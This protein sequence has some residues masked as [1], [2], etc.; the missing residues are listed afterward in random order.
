MVDL[1]ILYD[2]SESDELGIRLTAE[3]KEIELEYIPFYKI[4]FGFNKNKFTFQSTGKD[5]SQVIKDC[6]VVLNR[7]QSKNRRIFAAS[8]MEGL[9]KEVV[10]PLNVETICQSKIRSLLKFM[11]K[12]INI[13]KTVYVPCNVKEEMASGEYIDNTNTIIRLVENQLVKNIVIKPDA[14]THG[15]SVS[16]AKNSEDLMK[17][18]NQL[19]T[20]ITN[21][22]GVVAQELIPKWFYDLRIIVSKEKNKKAFC[23]PT[24]LV[25]GGFKEFRTNTFLGNMVFHV[26]L[27]ENVKKQAE[28]C[29]KA[30]AND[31][32]AWLIALD[33]MPN[34]DSKTY[35][36]ENELK[37]KFTE[38]QEPFE[39]V[40]KVKA[41]P[42]KKS[43]FVKYS[44]NVEKAYLKYKSNEAYAYIQEVVSK[45]L[46][47]T[48]DKVVFH[49]GNSCPEFWE[50]TRII[51]GINVAEPLLACAKSLLDR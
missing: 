11:E 24:A 33:A 19:Q 30:L 7:G 15:R 27:P 35:V 45:T 4:A 40:L 36:N 18:L 2:R 44:K 17:I 3:E 48:S 29:G 43:D 5:Y 9:N 8:I 51:A 16:L 26:N 39:E 42:N 1:A 50:Q 31:S 37:Q 41:D 49:E 25:R 21:P 22:S 20:D 10:N 47:K 46:H 23:E 14:G 6:K 34:I 32:E 38:L 28:K 13:P 12:G